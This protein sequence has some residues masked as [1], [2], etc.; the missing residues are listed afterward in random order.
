MGWISRGDTI[1]DEVLYAFRAVGMMDFDEAEDQTTPLEWFDTRGT[2]DKAGIPGWIHLSFHDHPPL[3]FFVQHIFINIF[4]ETNFAFRLPSALLGV[5][6]VYLLY[7]IGLVLY[8]ES[9]GL[10]AAALF[11]VTANHVYISRVGL[12]ESYVIFFIMLASYF[13][14]RSL[15]KDS[16]LI[17]TGVALGLAF[18]TKYTTFV[19]VPIFLMYLLFFRRDYFRNKKFWI[20][21]GIAFIVFSPVLVYNFELY[22]RVGH[23]DFQLSYI[24]KQNPEVWR[25]APGKEIGSMGDRVKQFFPNLAEINSW[26]FLFF[27]ASALVVFISRLAVKPREVFRKHAFLIIALFYFSLLLAG[28][29]PSYRFLSMLTPFI[30][31]GI[32]CAILD[33]GRLARRP[34]S[35][36]LGFQVGLIVAVLV[37]EIFY[38]VNSQILYYPKGPAPWAYSYGVRHENFNWGYNELAEYLGA[39]LDGKMPAVA[40]G[41]RYKFLDD[42]HDSA[43]TQAAQEKKERYS[44]VIIYDGNVQNIAQLW[45]LDRLNI[46]HAWPVV[47]TEQYLAFMSGNRFVDIMKTGFE[48]YY[49]IIP[50]D[51]VP[52]KGPRHQSRLGAEFERELVARGIKP[53]SIKNKRHEEAFRV[54]KF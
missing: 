23:F 17:W 53:V 9:V 14:L 27:G 18:L 42:L 24:F 39:E 22:R 34:T 6:S 46:Y 19:L 51:K 54:Y 40:F 38:S 26:L 45:V 41:M 7:L 1:T 44:A 47:K 52:Q 2:E 11:A 31:L 48:H 29:G 8:S 25:V 16:Y 28:I 50:T 12:Q 43:T 10:V 21:A 37:F 36:K 3:V 35:R 4:G 13:F 5:A 30:A 49:F 15:K 32:A 33:V 20:G